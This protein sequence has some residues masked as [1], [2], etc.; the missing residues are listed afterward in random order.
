[1][2]GNEAPPAVISMFIGDDLSEVFTAI[3]SGTKYQDRDADEVEFC[4]GILPHLKKDKTD[5]NRTSPFAFTGN[6]FEFRMVGS[7]MSVA[8]ANIVL[9]TI[10]AEQC[11]IIADK[12]ENAENIDDAI[13]Y[14]IV[15]AIR[16]HGRIIFNGNNYS[17]EWVEEAKKRGLHNLRNTPEALLHYVAPKNINLFLKHG[18]YTETEMRSRCEIL[19]ENYAKRINIEALTMVEMAKRDILPA[20]SAH[21]KDLTEIISGKMSI[22]SSLNCDYENKILTKLSDLSVELYNSADKL[23]SAVKKIKATG[24]NADIAMAYKNKVVPLMEKVRKIADELEVNT[25]SKYWPYPTY[26]DLLFG[27]Q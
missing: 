25:G 12:L 22:S 23:E 17:E 7:N 21:I 4:E 16:K 18:I 13:D 14:L 2:G 1:L 3:E 19:L 8:D 10:V 20:V 26:G 9:N 15:K 24:N 6:K 5:R 11:M 27:I